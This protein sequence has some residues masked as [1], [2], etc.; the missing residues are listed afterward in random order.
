MTFDSPTISTPEIVNVVSA[1][2]T[3]AIGLDLQGIAA[4]QVQEL[5]EKTLQLKESVDRQ[6]IEDVTNL[7]FAEAMLSSN[8]LN[9]FALTDAMGEITARDAG[10]RSI[11]YPSAGF[12]SLKLRVSTLFGQPLSVTPAGMGMDIDRDLVVNV[13]KDGD[14]EKPAAVTLAQ[15]IFGSAM[16]AQSPIAMLS[17]SEA[18]VRG[19]ATMQLLAM[20][21]DQRI[22]IHHVTSAN[23]AQVVPLLEIDTLDR[24]QVES[25]I[26]AGLEV[27]LPQEAID[28]EGR[29]LLGLILFDPSTGSGS[30][31][32][33]D[34]NGSHLTFNE[35]LQLLAIPAIWMGFALAFIVIGGPVLQLTAALLLLVAGPMFFTMLI[36]LALGGPEAKLFNLTPCELGFFLAGGLLGAA[37]ILLGGPAGAVVGTLLAL[38]VGMIGTEVCSE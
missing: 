13:A 35:F 24:Q 27:I 14:P 26:A 32:I 15:G 19:I 4:S 17:S 5:R 12:F 36:L 16:E 2:E 22:P 23:A 7:K 28:F 37:G 20:A 11:R 25:A 9:W 1:G 21:S 3:A 33:G 6:S 10:V 29:S 38:I 34:T 31:L 18:P 30:F 8:I